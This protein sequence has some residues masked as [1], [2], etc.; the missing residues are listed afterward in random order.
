[1]D[2][3]TYETIAES[4]LQISEYAEMAEDLKNIAS[5][6]AEPS[7]KQKLNAIASFLERDLPNNFFAGAKLTAY[8]IFKLLQSDNFYS[9]EEI[10]TK[11]GKS[12]STAKQTINALKKGG[13]VIYESVAK[14]YKIGF[15][16]PAKGRNI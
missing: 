10:A 14:G 11:I 9:N 12:A 16:R 7:H 3:R 6:V 8:Q 15:G 5:F 1:M 4:A 2:K 13:I